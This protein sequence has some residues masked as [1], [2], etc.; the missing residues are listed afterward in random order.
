MYITLFT[1]DKV[2]N[3]SKS[4]TEVRINFLPSP[5]SPPSFLLL[6]PPLFSS[7]L[8]L[9]FPPPPAILFHPTSPTPS[10]SPPRPILLIFLQ[11]LPSSSIFYSFFFTT[12]PRFYSSSSSYNY[13][14]SNT[15]SIFS[16]A[17]SSSETSSSP[18]VIRAMSSTRNAYVPLTSTWQV[19]TE[20]RPIIS[21][22]SSP[23]S[24]VL[25]VLSVFR[26]RLPLLSLNSTS[27]QPLL[28]FSLAELVNISNNI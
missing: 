17:W 16:F 18:S 19:I 26:Y 11:L 8:L 13:F 10:S 21:S 24:I 9:F 14:S 15:S 1:F 4:I 6:P 27:F 20:I 2:I 28:L 3:Y 7:S 22:Y 12:F 5:V 23:R 25:S